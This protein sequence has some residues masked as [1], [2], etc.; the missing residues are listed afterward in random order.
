MSIGEAVHGERVI[1]GD[2]STATVLKLYKSGNF[3]ASVDAVER[4]LA[5]DEFLNI[6]DVV[7][8]DEEAAD[9]MLVADAAAAGKY[10]VFTKSVIGIPIV[11]NFNKDY[12][13]VCPKG[14]VPKFTGGSG[15]A[16]RSM[17]IIQGFITK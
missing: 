15:A 2:A 5:T 11:V 6:T 9:V 8:I 16:A 12:P 17:C 4:E 3:D 13:Y 7:I 10:I 1:D 14:V